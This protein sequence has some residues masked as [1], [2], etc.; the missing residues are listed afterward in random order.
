M[1][2]LMR[3]VHCLGRA[4]RA[5][6]QQ[7][8]KS[9]AR[10][11]RG[12]INGLGW[13]LRR[14]TGQR[15]IGHEKFFSGTGA[16][17]LS[18]QAVLALRC[19]RC[20]RAW[21]HEAKQGRPVLFPKRDQPELDARGVQHCQQSLIVRGGQVD[22]DAARQH[23]IA[24]A[25]IQCK[26]QARQDHHDSQQGGIKIDPA[27][28]GHGA[29][30]VAELQAGNV[31]SREGFKR[32]KRHGRHQQHAQDGMD[33]AG[34]KECALPADAVFHHQAAGKDGQG[35]AKCPAGCRQMQ[36]FAP[37]LGLER[38]GRA[39]PVLQ[40]HGRHAGAQLA[41]V[42]V[43]G[44]QAVDPAHERGRRWP[45]VALPW[46]EIA[47]DK[48][49]I[50]DQVPG[51]DGQQG[52]RQQVDPMRVSNAVGSCAKNKCRQ[53]C[54]HCQPLCPWSGFLQRRQRRVSVFY[55]AQ[56]LRCAFLQKR[57]DVD[58]VKGWNA[59][60]GGQ[61]LSGG[62]QGKAVNIFTLHRTEQLALRVGGFNRLSQRHAA[63][64]LLV[65]RDAFGALVHESD[66]AES[67]LPPRR[68]PLDELSRP[69][70]PLGGR[71]GDVS[72]ARAQIKAHIRPE[73]DVP[74]NAD[75]V[76]HRAMPIAG[77]VSFPEL[78]AAASADCCNTLLHVPCGPALESRQ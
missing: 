4:G 76:L 67:A 74:D 64:W 56:N 77:S 15:D 29:A 19:M 46:Q 65:N 37:A 42:A 11:A 13:R 20:W 75:D 3:A 68:I 69:S 55:D 9:P 47:R 59:V 61:A 71:H 57:L 70:Q 52:Q 28:A 26:P 54:S 43:P 14:V 12:T 38:G 36:D 60:V 8:A 66:Y 44:A 45:P 32:E 63:R 17:H 33:L 1:R 2:G 30:A 53:E 41:G 72:G 51:N 62:L 27:C 22:D 48:E 31:P 5:H 73:G 16:D 7:T 50:N 6:C 25:C 58:G 34:I 49:A 10:P 18:Q 39:V 40:E 23:P 24:P 35:N 21:P 78:C